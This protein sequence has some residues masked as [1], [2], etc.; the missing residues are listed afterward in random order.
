MSE[1]AGDGHTLSLVYFSLL[2]SLLTYV[3]ASQDK[4]FAVIHKDAHM[5]ADDFTLLF[6]GSI[7]RYKCDV[8]VN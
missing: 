2:P 1:T 8:L 4:N 6:I 7:D 3:K 5:D